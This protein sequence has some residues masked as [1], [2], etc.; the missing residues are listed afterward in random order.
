MKQ[1]NN[2]IWVP[3]DYIDESLWQSI[4]DSH[5]FWKDK[6]V[7]ENTGKNK[8]SAKLSLAPAQD[9]QSM[10]EYTY[11]T[12]NVTGDQRLQSLINQWAGLHEAMY[13]EGSIVNISL[14]CIAP[15]GKLEYRIGNLGR[16]ECDEI[17]LSSPD[18]WNRLVEDSLCHQTVL[19]LRM[20]S[21]DEFM[22]MGMPIRTT[23]GMLFEF[24]N[25]LPHAINNKGVDYTVF[26][27]TTWKNQSEFL[28]QNLIAL[29]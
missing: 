23:P 6:S 24:D 19:T 20:N 17:D 22:V 2:R 12:T 15:G 9:Y 14:L 3:L 4:L 5:N 28:Q 10:D 7:Y 26:L 25:A 1:A 11:A 29:T 18:Y 8:G 13:G 16:K 21:L 27:V